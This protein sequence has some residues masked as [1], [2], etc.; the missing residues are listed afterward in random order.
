[1]ASVQII[2]KNKTQYVRIVESYWD[3]EVK[4]PK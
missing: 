3:K 1:M 4:K 2:K